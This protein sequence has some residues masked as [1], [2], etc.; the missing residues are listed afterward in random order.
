MSRRGGG[1]TLL[2]LQRP[3]CARTQSSTTLGFWKAEEKTRALMLASDDSLSVSKE[4]HLGNSSYGPWQYDLM[5][6]A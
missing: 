3:V 2:S 1:W 6:E 5:K 4:F